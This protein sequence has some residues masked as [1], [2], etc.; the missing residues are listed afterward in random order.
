MSTARVSAFV[1]RHLLLLSQER[2]TEVERTSVVFSK[3][4][5]K[6]L[7][8]KGL[9]L[10]GL[11]IVSIGVGLGNK[12]CVRTVF[13]PSINHDFERGR[14]V[15]LERPAACH[16]VTVFPPHTFRCDAI[17]NLS[18]L[19]QTRELGPEISRQLRNILH[20]PADPGSLP[21]QRVH[22]DET[23]QNQLW[24]VSSTRYIYTQDLSFEPN[25]PL[26]CRAKGHGVPHCYRHQSNAFG[27]R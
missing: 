19:A 18:P 7:E 22:Q 10:N 5:P 16:T 12:T 9:A 25:H 8:Q 21:N 23:R 27:T 2:D 1:D 15:E 24:R 6:L 3:C 20:P 4:G 11:G 14:L 26:N 13:L 17:P